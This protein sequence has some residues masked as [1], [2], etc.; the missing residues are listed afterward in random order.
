MR[1]KI[2][3]LK[4]FS[5]NVITEK[6][7]LNISKN[8]KILQVKEKTLKPNNYNNDEQNKNLRSKTYIYVSIFF[9]FQDSE[10]SEIRND[11][12]L[13]KFQNQNKCSKSVFST[14]AMKPTS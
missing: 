5:A 2:L 8:L 10:E 7:N 11:Q 13:K 4:K 14:L 9:F 3:N 1:N 12:K 6:K